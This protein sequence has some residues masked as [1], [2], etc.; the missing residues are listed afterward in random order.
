MSIIYAAATNASGTGLLVSY[1]KMVGDCSWILGTS[2][3]Q[4]GVSCDFSLINEKKLQGPC[5]GSKGGGGGGG[6]GGQR[7]R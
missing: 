2:W 7:Q 3:Q 6:G 5:L 1:F 4:H